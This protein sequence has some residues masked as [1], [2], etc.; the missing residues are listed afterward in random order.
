MSRNYD[1]PD[2]YFSWESNHGSAGIRKVMIDLSQV[3]SVW[4]EPELYG[5]SYIYIGGQ[6][7]PV[8]ASIAQSVF[9]LL[10]HRA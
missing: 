8:T 1:P 2:R 3:T 9:S 7:Y 10:E 4:V 6:R 5:E